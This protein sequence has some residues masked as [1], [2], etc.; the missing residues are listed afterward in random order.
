MVDVGPK[1]DFEATAAMRKFVNLP[2][3][4]LTLDQLVEA[5]VRGG[6]RGGHDAILY[7]YLHMTRIGPD[8]RL[9]WRQDNRSPHDY[10]HILDKIQE[11]N[12]LAPAIA[13]KILITRGG[14]SRI[15]TDDKVAAFAA[16]FRHGRWVTIPEAGHNI[17][18]DKP[19][20]LATAL[21]DFLR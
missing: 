1:P 2:I 14:R 13:C 3:V 11:L 17:Q 7:R 18:E 21:D 9:T 5:A 4:D 19:M 8:R 6:A 10:A 16:R 12:E 15:L 20:A